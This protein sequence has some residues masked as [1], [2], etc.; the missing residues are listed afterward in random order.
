MLQ[1]KTRKR[2]FHRFV[3]RQNSVKAQNYSKTLPDLVIMEFIPLM[4]GRFLVLDLGL[5]EQ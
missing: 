4:A 3:S 2:K 5:R 1:N